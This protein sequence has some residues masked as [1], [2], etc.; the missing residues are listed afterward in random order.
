MGVLNSFVYIIKVQTFEPLVRENRVFF[1]SKGANMREKE[2][3]YEG[4]CLMGARGEEIQ[5]GE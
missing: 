1:S 3:P 5:D 4:C 2:I